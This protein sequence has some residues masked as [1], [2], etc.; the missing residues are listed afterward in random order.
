MLHISILGDSVSTFYNMSP[1]D[2][3]FYDHATAF[4]AEILSAEE[5]WWMRVIRKKDGILHVNNSYAG[6]GVTTGG[7]DQGR[8]EHR[9]LSLRGSDAVIIFLVLNDAAGGLLPVDFET[10]YRG[11]IEDIQNTVPGADIFCLTLPKARPGKGI[12]FR[13]V[14]WAAPLRSYNQAIKTAAAGTGACVLDI[15]GRLS[16]YTAMDGVHPDKNGME[17]IAA[18]CLEEWK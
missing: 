2:G 15:A 14:E 18:A 17:Q 16:Y 13:N 12:M 9:L 8:A 5:T 6:T 10:A 3:V 7:V 11:L 4:E 1:S